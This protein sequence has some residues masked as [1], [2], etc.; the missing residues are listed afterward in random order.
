MKEN[1]TETEKNTKHSFE[2]YIK[3][4]TKTVC[5][6]KK[7]SCATYEK[8]VALEF[9]KD[10]PNYNITPREIHSSVYRALQRLVKRGEF[11]K[12]EKGYYPHIPEYNHI[13]YGNVIKNKFRFACDDVHV[14]SDNTCIITLDKNTPTHDYAIYNKET[15]DIFT[16]Y[17]GKDNIY[18]IRKVDNLVIIMLR[19]ARG[20]RYIITRIKGLVKYVY[21]QQS[22]AKISLYKN[23]A[24]AALPEEY[25]YYWFDKEVCCN[26]GLLQK[27]RFLFVQCT[28]INVEN[29]YSI[30]KSHASDLCESLYMGSS[31]ITLIFDIT[32]DLSDFETFISYIKK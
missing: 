13:H 31:S 19:K 27:K 2:Y 14:L 1:L 11:F 29:I 4:V 18:L 32:S 28:P 20:A 15:L 3:N 16:D 9:N 6:Q 21:E 7:P 23:S 22:S 24:R 8:A 12:L 30:I 5:K 26:D 25:S 17:V 10:H